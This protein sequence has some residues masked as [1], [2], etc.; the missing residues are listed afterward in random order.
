MQKL[1]ILL[2]FI[3]SQTF[4]QNKY[5]LSGQTKVL[6]FG[7]IY[8]V[9]LI[10]D[11]TY[12]KG[13]K[14]LDSSKITNGQ[15][16]FVRQTNSK[17]VY[18]YYFIITDNKIYGESGTVFL[19]PKD[20]NVNILTLD[21]YSAPYLTPSNYQRE[22]KFQYE[23]FFKEI[24]T[25]IGALNEDYKRID[26]IYNGKYPQ[27][28]TDRLDE[29]H[30]TIIRS[31]DS[32]FYQYCKLYPNSKLSL[33]KLIERFTNNGYNQIYE[34]IFS[35]FPKASLNTYAAS[36]LD[37]KLKSSQPI[38]LNNLFPILKL[39]TLENKAQEFNI[40]TFNSK[41]VLVDF[42]F[43]N[44]G[45]CIS[46]FPSLMEIYKKY[47]PENFEIVSISSDRS[48]KYE[49]LQIV[50]TLHKLPWLNLWDENGVICDEL[51]IRSYPTNLLINETG[52]IIRRNISP[53]DLGDLIAD[54]LVKKTY[55]SNT[56]EPN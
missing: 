22:L 53:T 50:S 2:L 14:I 41:L 35:Q 44:C 5:V 29:K 54:K 26:S 36:V 3:S 56:Y 7:D 15:F 33:W 48:E 6:E 9:G 17:E 45:P 21:P 4:P 42:W 31:G 49:N 32:L 28:E 46:Q 1:L 37:Q 39:K 40:D 25:E 12:Y 13:I 43:S 19:E 24:V 55:F 8:L 38:G 30:N 23:A 18:P 20:Q 11:T 27:Y 47:K 10:N 16:Q 51:S 52:K 34:S